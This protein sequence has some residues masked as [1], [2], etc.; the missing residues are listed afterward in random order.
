MSINLKKMKKNL[1]L[2]LTDVWCKI[3]AVVVV[4]TF[5]YFTGLLIT[6]HIAP[7]YFGT[8]YLNLA[9]LFGGHM[10]YSVQEV[11]HLSEEA[12]PLHPF[13][14]KNIKPFSF[15]LIYLQF[16][17]IL[18]CSFL[19][20]K[21][22]IKFINSVKKVDS[23]KEGNVVS[24]KKMGRYF[25]FIFLLSGFALVVADNGQFKGLFFNFTAFSLM[26]ASYIM[27]EIFKQG[28]VLQEDVQS[29]I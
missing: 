3:S 12:A 13:A 10:G 17:A 5:L 20:F 22:G 18:C 29:T 27:A 26:A 21:E 2:T 6:Y 28:N 9:G 14:L 16:S 25:F 23:F 24:L 19:V 11:F 1:L 8:K 4:L 7:D 15:Y